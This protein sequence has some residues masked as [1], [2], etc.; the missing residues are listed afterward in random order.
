VTRRCTNCIRHLQ[1]PDIPAEEAGLPLVFCIEGTHGYPYV[2]WVFPDPKY[3]Q[4]PQI[5]D[6]GLRKVR[7]RFATVRKDLE[8]ALIGKVRDMLPQLQKVEYPSDSSGLSDHLGPDSGGSDSGHV[9]L[10]ALKIIGR[11]DK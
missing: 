6:E 11:K 10:S 8:N 3:I 7:R 4:N 1:R 5:D 9:L 2:R